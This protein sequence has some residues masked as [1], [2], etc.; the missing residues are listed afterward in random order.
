LNLKTKIQKFNFS[1]NVELLT[2]QEVNIVM[3][4]SFGFGGNNTTLI[5]GKYKQQ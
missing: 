1:P 4:N 3:S 5:I 2:N